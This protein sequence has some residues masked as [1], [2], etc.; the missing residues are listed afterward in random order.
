MGMKR[1]FPL[2][3]P[4]QHGT[5]TTE[6]RGGGTRRFAGTPQVTILDGAMG[7]ELRKMNPDRPW[8]A[9]ARAAPPSRQLLSLAHKPTRALNNSRPTRLR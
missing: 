1:E 4:K 7:D 5:G 2:D 8:C 6:R 3:S 9:A